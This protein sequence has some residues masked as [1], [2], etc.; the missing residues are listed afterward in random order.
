MSTQYPQIFL[1]R[2]GETEWTLSGRHTGRSDIPLTD[3]GENA[4]RL[5]KQRIPA[6]DFH[7][8]F[9]SPSQRARKTC[10]LAGFSER[11][12]I[13]DNLA[14][15]DYG[16]YE[17]I[18]TKDIQTQ[19]PGWNIFK[20][21]CPDGETVLDVSNRAD[22]VIT[23]IRSISGNVLIFSSSHFLRVFAARWLGLDAVAGSCFILDTTSISI[24]G[25]EHNLDEPVVRSWNQT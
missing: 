25:Y 4:A 6:I 12:E 19:Q 24:L 15:W 17:G 20:N 21:G 11:V 23:K 10:E 3:N 18:M 5:L 22:A 9:S 2:H 14:E 7:A 13:D 8:V 1:V 16:R